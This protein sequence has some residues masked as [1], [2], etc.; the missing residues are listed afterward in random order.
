MHK[1]TERTSYIP[2]PLNPETRS[3]VIL[4]HLYFTE[5]LPHARLPIS[6]RRLCV[7]NV[8]VSIT[9]FQVSQGDFISLNENDAIIYSKTRRSLY[10]QVSV[11]KIIGKSLD[12]LVRIWRRS[13]T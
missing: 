12:S 2:F 13:K 10:I 5:T 1:G 3:D 11:S 4:V 7:N 8:I 6:H 9:S